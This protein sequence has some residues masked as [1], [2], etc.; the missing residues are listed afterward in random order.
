MLKKV[1]NAVKNILLIIIIFISSLLIV[2][3]GYYSSNYSSES[4]DQVLYWCSRNIE[5]CGKRYNTR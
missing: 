3:A 2:G 5:G 4:F 1:R